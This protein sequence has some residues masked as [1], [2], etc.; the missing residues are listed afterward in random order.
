M[1]LL[2]VDDNFVERSY[3]GRS[4]YTKLLRIDLVLLEKQEFLLCETK[5]RNRATIL[6]PQRAL[7]CLFLMSSG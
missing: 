3:S 1:K 7:L 4:A 6:S 2:S 5:S